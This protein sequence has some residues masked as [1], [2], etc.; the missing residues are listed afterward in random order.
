MSYESGHRLLQS[1]KTM[2][3]IPTRKHLATPSVK[4]EF[5]DIITIDVSVAHPGNRI[6]CSKKYLRPISSGFE[7]EMI[8]VNVLL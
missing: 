1:V 3:K 8:F 4:T 5:C 2:A 7:I 6:W